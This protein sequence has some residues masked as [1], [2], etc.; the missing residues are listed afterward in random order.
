MN[1]LHFLRNSP[2]LARLAL[3]WFAMTL[4]VA[5]AS[6]MVH[7]HEELVICTGA[8]ML[9]VVL[10][11]DGTV[12]T[13]ATSD[14]SDGL[15]CPLCMVGTAPAPLVFNTVEPPQPLSHV[16]QTIPAARI[17]A[18]TAAPLPARGPPHA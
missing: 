16:L 17:A 6:P 12:T 5:V 2:W 15:F 14:T 8:G 9:K 3:L 18:L 4:G 11:D 7:P 13:A 10:A 1:P